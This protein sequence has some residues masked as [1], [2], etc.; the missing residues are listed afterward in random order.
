[1]HLFA[2]L[3]IAIFLLLPQIIIFISIPFSF[4]PFHSHFSQMYL[5][6]T[7]TL[8]LWVPSICGRGSQCKSRGA[9]QPPEQC[10]GVFSARHRLICDQR[11]HHKSLWTSWQLW[12]QSPTHNENS[13]PAV[14]QELR[15][16]CHLLV[17]IEDERKLHAYPYTF[18]TNEV[19]ESPADVYTGGM[20]F[21]HSQEMFAI[22]CSVRTITNVPV[23]Y[24]PLQNHPIVF[25]MT[26]LGRS[27]PCTALIHKLSEGWT[28]LCWAIRPHISSFITAFA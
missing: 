4:F 24:S 16:C 7:P 19:P 20:N 28:S 11:W 14:L 17:P 12:R 6:P 23:P 3:S 21:E 1:M 10:A 13:S 15:I 18:I 22:R 5:S 25:S 26:I 2:T 8:S 9:M 27:C